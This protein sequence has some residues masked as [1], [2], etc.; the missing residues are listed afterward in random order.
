M[1][2]VF[3]DVVSTP[4]QTTINSDVASRRTTFQE[5]PTLGKSQLI[6]GEARVKQCESIESQ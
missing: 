5:T 4:Q 2:T 6:D 3:S 1:S